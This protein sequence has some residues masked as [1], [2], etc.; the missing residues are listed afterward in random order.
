MNYLIYAI[1][2]VLLAAV[3]LAVKVAFVDKRPQKIG[4]LYMVLAVPLYVVYYNDR[5]P[6]TWGELRMRD[7]A[8]PLQDY[9]PRADVNFESHIAPAIMVLII[10]LVY[11]VVFQRVAVRR[12]LARISDPIATF[13]AGSVAA[14]M[15]GGT[16]V[17][18]FH[19]GWLGAVGISVGFALIYLG[20]L[21]LL[22]AILELMAAL[23][24]LF[25]VWIQRRIFA[26]ATLI[27]RAASWISS[28]GGRL[29]PRSFVEAIRAD[30]A[31]QEAMFLVEQ[32]TQDRW[33]EAGFD[34]DRARRNA[35]RTS[36]RGR[37]VA[38]I[39]EQADATAAS[40]AEQTSLQT[41]GS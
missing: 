36:R 37:T 28:L 12:R 14:T 3:V 2:V 22:A 6:K 11:L 27:T 19:W 34:R 30:T 15:F 10:L 35:G 31:R 33:I 25:G 38:P 21:A 4:L 39:E 13:L 26:V 7:L 32:D 9:T 18:T 41:S 20:A 1:A 8:K 5:W 17:S 29:V 24:R 40:S 16:L 23:A